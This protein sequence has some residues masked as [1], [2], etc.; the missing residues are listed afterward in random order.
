[1]Q[2]NFSGW[3]WQRRKRI[4]G[5]DVFYRRLASLFPRQRPGSSKALKTGK[6]NVTVYQENG[7]FKRE[8][9]GYEV[10]GYDEEY[11]C[12]PAILEAEVIALCLYPEDIPEAAAY[13]GK[14]HFGARSP[15][16]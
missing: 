7:T 6:Y 1:M 11:S 5:R 16:W 10:Y 4:F 13:L 2:C 15:K 12:L 8:I 14:G 9:T 3:R